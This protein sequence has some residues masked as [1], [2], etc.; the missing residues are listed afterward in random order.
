MSALRTAK[1]MTET[2]FV[3]SNINEMITASCI[4]A[5]VLTKW[6]LTFTTT[7]YF[8]IFGHIMNLFSL[9][10][11]VMDA[12]CSPSMVPGSSAGTAMTLTSVKTALKLA[13]TTPD[14]RLA[15]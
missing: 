2:M 1:K 8:S 6:N 4:M 7:L 11:G 9:F 14:I 13:N 3:R 5:A 15:E 10:L 12:K